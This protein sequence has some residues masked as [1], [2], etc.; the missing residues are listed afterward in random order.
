[1]SAETAVEDFG[2]DGIATALGRSVPAVMAAVAAVLLAAGAVGIVAA[3]FLYGVGVWGGRW[4]GRLERAGRGA[5]FSGGV[6]RVLGTGNP[7]VLCLL[8]LWVAVMLLLKESVDAVSEPLSMAEGSRLAERPDP[9]SIVG[10]LA[11]MNPQVEV[12]AFVVAMLGGI[13]GFVAGAIDGLWI[14]ST[15]ERLGV[16]WWKLV[17]GWRGWR[18]W[19]RRRGERRRTYWGAAG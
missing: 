4:I 5:W 8:A 19:A 13:T 12:V 1:M 2:R 7:R 6:V 3:L 16:R 15:S 9:G 10:R 14:G 11:E 18:D 17:F